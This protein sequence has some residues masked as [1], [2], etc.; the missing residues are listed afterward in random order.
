MV[1]VVENCPINVSGPVL[2]N[3]FWEDYILEG[4]LI[5]VP[6]EPFA[7]PPWGFSSFTKHCVREADLTRQ[8]PS[9]EATGRGGDKEKQHLLVLQGPASQGLLPFLDPCLGWGSPYWAVPGGE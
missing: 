8:P 2:F 7:A 9:A 3:K 5:Q 4:H 6:V 1:T